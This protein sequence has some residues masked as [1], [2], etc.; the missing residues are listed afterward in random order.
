VTEQDLQD[1]EWIERCLNNDQVAFERIYNKYSSWLYSVCLRYVSDRD[2]A[3]DI[4]QDSFILIFNN[5]QQY[6][7]EAS[8]R[9]WMK[10]ITVNC[11]LG[12]FRKKN[13]GL[14]AKSS[15]SV[16]DQIIIDVDFVNE[17]EVEELHYFIEKLS[18]GRKQVFN[19]YI[20]EGFSHKEISTM[21]GI[22][23]GTSKSQLFD[24]KRELKLAIEH[25]YAVAKPKNL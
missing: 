1:I 7:K 10:K 24:A 2:E 11:A 20:I 12:T 6:S 22:S 15:G 5:L 3:Q 14:L 19:A 9:G 13:A 17:M 25:K 4:L 18:P 16:E 8:F 21:M 23:E